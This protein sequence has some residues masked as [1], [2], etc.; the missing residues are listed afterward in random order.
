MDR[1]VLDMDDVTAAD[2]NSWSFRAI[3]MGDVDCTMTIDNGLVS[4]GGEGLVTSGSTGSECVQNND[5]ITIEVKGSA[6]QPVEGYQLGMQYDQNKLQYL[7]SSAGNIT[8]YSSDNFNVRNGEIKTMWNKFNFQPESMETQK[9]LFKLHFKALNSFCGLTGVF[10]LNEEVLPATFYNFN[11]APMA[12]N[13]ELT[14]QK[15]TPT[16]N[17][18][19]LYPNPTTNSATFSFLLNQPGLVTIRLSDYLGGTLNMNQTYNAGTFTYTF[20]SLS[21]LVSGP[22]NYT[23]QI[24]NLTYSGVLV[25]SQP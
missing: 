17:L 11:V 16:G 9:T 22:L 24:G 4:S 6:S 15:Q 5:V 12:A 18:I 8:D 10:N 21:S 20:P 19:S 14:Y 3:K 25:K 2:P 7:G 1:V 13:I 23:I